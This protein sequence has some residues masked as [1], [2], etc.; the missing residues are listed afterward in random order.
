MQTQTINGAMTINNPGDGP[1]TVQW[2]IG[3][4]ITF[5]DNDGGND[6]T[7]RADIAT[8]SYQTANNSGGVISTQQ[9]QTLSINV[10]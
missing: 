3:G 4:S 2:D 1:A 5:V 9:S 10:Q 8:I 7:Y 6:R